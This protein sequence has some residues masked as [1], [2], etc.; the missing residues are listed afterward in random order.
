MGPLPSAPNGFFNWAV[1]PPLNSQL[2]TPVPH[3]TATGALPSPGPQGRVIKE[4][5]LQP[6]AIKAQPYPLCL[7]LM[8]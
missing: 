3:P 6:E 5:M 7:S 8:S 4:F 1:S 2:Q